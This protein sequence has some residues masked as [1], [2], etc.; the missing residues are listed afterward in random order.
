MILKMC[1]LNI[2][3]NTK[4]TIKPP[5]NSCLW[6]LWG[7]VELPFRIHIF[8]KQKIERLRTPTTDHRQRNVIT[9][10]TLSVLQEVYQP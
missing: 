3:G 7:L 1:F 9:N 5:Y 2:G 8:V 10:A 6:L 4:P